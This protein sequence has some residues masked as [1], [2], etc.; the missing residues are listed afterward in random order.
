MPDPDFPEPTERFTHSGSSHWEWRPEYEVP[1]PKPDD[2][3]FPRRRVVAKRPSTAAE[4]E[5]RQK[6]MRP[7][8]VP[9]FCLH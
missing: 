2:P 1:P 6:R 7:E 3:V 9:E 8:T 4:E 5:V